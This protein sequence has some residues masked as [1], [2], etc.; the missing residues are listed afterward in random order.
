MSSIRTIFFLLSLAIL[1][2]LAWG[3]MHDLLVCAYTL[4][5]SL[6]LLSIL[7]QFPDSDFLLI[8]KLKEIELQKGNLEISVPRKKKFQEIAHKHID[9]AEFLLTKTRIHDS[10]KLINDTKKGL[11]VGLIIYLFLFLGG[12]FTTYLVKHHAAKYDPASLSMYKDTI[13]VV[14][15][16]LAFIYIIYYFSPVN[17]QR[18][19]NKGIIEE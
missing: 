19:H 6:F 10:H 15:I 16:G 1:Q 12:V 9:L 4:I 2:M 5:N 8:E 18:N 13:S 17:S 11:T 3:F 7:F 14:Y